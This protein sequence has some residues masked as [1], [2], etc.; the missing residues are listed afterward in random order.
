MVCCCRRRRQQTIV[1]ILSAIAFL[2]C[3]NFFGPVVNQRK[4]RDFS[5]IMEF[6]LK[7]YHDYQLTQYNRTGPGEG[8]KPVYLDEK[9]SKERREDIKKEGFNIVASDRISLMRSIPDVRDP[10]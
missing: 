6:R 5:R 7:R 8:G 2:V 9:E 10:L 3:Y 4:E 1:G